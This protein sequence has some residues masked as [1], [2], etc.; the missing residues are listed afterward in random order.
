MKMEKFVKNFNEFLTENLN[1]ATSVLNM[2]PRNDKE[3]KK[4]VK[5]LRNYP[6]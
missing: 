2:Q 6:F 3:L 5:K 1:E 4:L